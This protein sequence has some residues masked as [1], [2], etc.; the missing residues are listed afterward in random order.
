MTWVVNKPEHN[1]TA[2]YSGLTEVTS[3]PTRIHYKR[4][5][6]GSVE[7]L[8]SD[9]TTWG[10]TISYMA[11]SHVTDGFLHDYTPD[12]GAASF[13]VTWILEHDFGAGYLMVGTQTHYVHATEPGSG[14]GGSGGTGLDI[15]LR[16][17]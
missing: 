10:A 16:P 3:G 11:V 6:S 8:Q 15:V 9:L 12:S 5:N 4:K 17:G 13:S 2:I 1:G 14:T 7:Y